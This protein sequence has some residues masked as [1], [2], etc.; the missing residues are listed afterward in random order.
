MIIFVYK[1]MFMKKLIRKLICTFKGH[2]W[3][4]YWT[5]YNGVIHCKCKRCEKT[6]ENYIWEFM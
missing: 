6:K 2:E 3:M 1:L 5:Y 4:V